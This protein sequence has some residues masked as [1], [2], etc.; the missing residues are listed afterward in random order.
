LF[1]AEDVIRSLPFN[2]SEVN[3]ASTTT[4]TGVSVPVS[5]PGQSAANLRGL[6]TNAT[7]VLVNGRRIAGSPAFQADGTVNL[8]TIPAA[9]IERVEV[10]LDGASAIYGSDALGGV[11]N[12]ILRKDWHGAESSIRA[13]VAS[14]DGDT[15][16]FS[17]VI[18]A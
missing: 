2:W 16:E 13:D 5:A 4:V 11:I 15:R 10:M 12:F 14:N 3:T 8:N 1:T 7:L 17:Q 6:G 9:A 18:G